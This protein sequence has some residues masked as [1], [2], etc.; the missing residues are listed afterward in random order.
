MAKQIKTQE[1][2]SGETRKQGN[3]GKAQSGGKAFTA[4]DEARTR[5]KENK[6]RERHPQGGK[7]L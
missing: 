5:M 3:E 6:K 2:E 1:P 7:G 4:L